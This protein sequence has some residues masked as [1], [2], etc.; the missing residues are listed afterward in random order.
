MTGLDE[1][2]RLP[3]RGHRKNLRMC[4]FMSSPALFCCFSTDVCV[5][6]IS[7]RR[8]CLCYIQSDGWMVDELKRIWKESIVA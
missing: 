2:A 1:G 5:C 6:V 3:L 8:Q 4:S 7:G